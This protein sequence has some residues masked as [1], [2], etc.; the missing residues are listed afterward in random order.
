MNHR[1]EK[2]RKTHINY[3]AG[4]LGSESGDWALGQNKLADINFS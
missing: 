3:G 4:A 1:G 2:E